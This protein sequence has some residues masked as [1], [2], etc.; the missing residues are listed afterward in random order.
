MSAKK[1][2]CAGRGVLIKSIAQAV[3]TYSI[4]CFLLPINICKKMRAAVANY[5]WGSS[6]DNRHMHW[7]SWERLTRSKNKGGMGFRD[8]RCFNLAMLGKQGWRLI[9]RPDSLCTRVLKGRYFHD[10]EFMLASRKRH[11]S[12]TWSHGGLLWQEE[13]RCN[14]G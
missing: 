10:S 12:S 1:A 2:S 8:L 5:W 7:M 3:P 11:A 9:T 6:A 14:M 4:S 13:K